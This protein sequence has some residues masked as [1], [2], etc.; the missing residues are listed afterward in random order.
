MHDQ[1]LALVSARPG[2]TAR[3]IAIAIDRRPS[4]VG[5]VLLRS[6]QRG[7]VRRERRAGTYRWHATASMPM[8]RTTLEHLE[9]EL[10]AIRAVID[11]HR[12]SLEAALMR[13]AAILARVMI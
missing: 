10:V 3:E 13:E 8:P 7:H 2:A 12:A 4:Y 11:G 6:M 1:V 5:D 9:D